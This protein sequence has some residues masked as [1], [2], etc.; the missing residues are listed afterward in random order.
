MSLSIEEILRFLG[1]DE[2]KNNMKQAMRIVTSSNNLFFCGKNNSTDGNYEIIA[3]CLAVSSLHGETHEIKGK[4]SK[5]GEIQNMSCSCKAGQS[6]KC[7]HVAAT[8][9]H[10]LG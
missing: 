9:L 3:R 1:S 4:I 2:S 7:K 5:K 8:L 6:E 10:C